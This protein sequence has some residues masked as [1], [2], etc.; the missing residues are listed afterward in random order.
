MDFF[1]KALDTIQIALENITDQASL[2]YAL[3]LIEMACVCGV[4]HPNNAAWYKI[5]ARMMINEEE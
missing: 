5:K 2:N 4:L 1:N 3:G